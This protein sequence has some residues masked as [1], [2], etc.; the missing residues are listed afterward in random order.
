MD[1]RD[2]I[3]GTALDPKKVVFGS[4]RKIQKLRERKVFACV[5]REIALHDPD[6]KL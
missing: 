6:I 3:T 1:E 2:E 5:E 4:F